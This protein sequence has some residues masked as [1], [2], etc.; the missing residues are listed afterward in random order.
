[1]DIGFVM[2]TMRDPAGVPAHPV[3][4]QGLMVFTWVFHIAFVQLTLGAAALA[5]YAFRKKALR[6]Y[7]EGT[8]QDP[9][10]TA[11]AKPLS[12]ADIANLAAF[13]SLQSRTSNDQTAARTLE[14][15]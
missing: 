10:M 9:T 8:R 1:M 12:D 5:I 13:F 11:M 14:T 4:F 6:A 3:L 7:R 15:R 2:N